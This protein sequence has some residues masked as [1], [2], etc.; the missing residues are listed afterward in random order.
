MIEN[1]KAI[2][3]YWLVLALS[4]MSAGAVWAKTVTP[5]QAKQLAAKAIGERLETCGERLETKVVFDAKDKQGQ[6]YLYAVHSPE[7]KGFVLVSGDDRFQRVLGYSDNHSFDEQ[8]MPEN[9]RAWLQ[10]YIDEMSYLESKGYGVSVTARG[11]RNAK[12][13]EKSAIAPMIE[14]L[15]GQSA[16]YN[17]LCPLYNETGHCKVGCVA[18]AMAQIINYHIQHYDAPATLVAEIPAYITEDF[19]Y[20]VEAVPAGTALP[21]KS[22]LLNSYVEETTDEQKEAVAQLSAYCGAAVHMNYR[23]GSSSGFSPDVPHALITYFGFDS[24][25]RLIQRPDYSYAAWMDTIYAELA[26]A[27]PV[28]YNGTSSD[29]GHAFIVDGYENGYF[30]INWGWIGTENGYFALSVLNPDDEGQIGASNSSDG[31]TCNQAA[32]IGIQINTGET[33]EQPVYLSAGDYHIEGNMVVF[34]AFNNTGMTRDFEYGIGCFDEDDEIYPI[35]VSKATV[36]NSYGWGRI[37]RTITNNVDL[38]NTSWKIIPISR[39]LGTEQWYPGANPDIN[40]FIADYDED[41]VPHLTAHPL[42]DLTVNS[43]TLGPTAS[44]FVNDFQDF[45]VSITNCGEEIYHPVYF[46]ADTAATIP[47]G[48]TLRTGMTAFPDS[49]QIISYMWMPVDTGTYNIWVTLDS[50]GQE[51]LAK[52]SVTIKEDPSLV[53]KDFIVS[54]IAFA[55]LDKNSRR[56]DELT[57][58]RTFDVYADSLFG[59]VELM[60]ISAEPVSY[61]LR[62]L[63]DKYDEVTGEF[64]PDPYTKSFAA[65]TIEPG[66]T[67]NLYIRNRSWEPNKTYRMRVLEKDTRK[68]LDCRY[69]F[70]LRSQPVPEDIEEITNDKSPMTKKVIKDGQILIL[71]GDKTYTLTGQE[72]K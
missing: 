51:I 17:N 35:Q 10:G 12:R 41:G 29:G 53:G 4:V 9:M 26:Q 21:D 15:W 36:K 44:K 22:L 18:T 52:T 16:P 64:I 28:Y 67:R 1:M 62:V 66:K 23:S 58:V 25:T 34:N 71:C 24:T 48:F 59:G 42:L 72:I 3:I 54:G 40:Y 57:G 65:K 47:S 27:R 69:I 30:H 20:S 56:V 61:A 5:E 33:F 7:Q 14:T 32:I 49:T 37:A 50:K 13:E 60:N 6:P 8:N 31:Y 38:A 63:F 68:E 43:V 45:Q 70:N 55:G 19:Q 11:A 39:E 46:F 2:R